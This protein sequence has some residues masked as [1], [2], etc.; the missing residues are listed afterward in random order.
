M[1]GLMERLNKIN[2]EAGG[3]REERKRKEKEE[4][5]LDDFTRL[6]KHISSQIKSVRIVSDT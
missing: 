3:G 2:D 6:K 1:N 4:K 5:A